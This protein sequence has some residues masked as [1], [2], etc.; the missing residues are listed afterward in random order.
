MTIKELREKT[1][2]TQQKFADKFHMTVDNV[3]CW[4]QGVS[5]PLKCIPFMVEKILELESQEVKK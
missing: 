2:L 1:G 4:E 3:R 5:S